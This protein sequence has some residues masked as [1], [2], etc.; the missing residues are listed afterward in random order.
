MTNRREFL[1]TATAILGLH[2]AGLAAAVSKPGGSRRGLQLQ[3]TVRNTGVMELSLVWVDIPQPADD[4]V[5]VRIEGAPINP[6]DLFMLFGPADLSSARVSGTGEKTVMT[7]DIPQQR[8]Q[9]LAN[10]VDKS[11]PAGNEGAGVVVATGASAAAQALLGRTVA[12]RAGA[13]YSQYRCVQARACLVLPQG[14]TPAQGASCFVNP[15]TVLCMVETMRREGYT[16]L[17]HTAAASN[18]GRML[19][20]LCMNEHIGLVNIV[21]R[22]EQV[23]L[24]QGLGAKYVCNSSLPAF[25]EDLTRALR[26]TGATLAFDAVGGGTLA[27]QILTAMENAALQ[28]GA[29]SSPYGSS[30]RKQ[31]YIY[32]GLDRSPTLLSGFYGTAWNVGGWLVMNVLQQIGAEA[33]RT[34]EQKIAAEI[35]TTFASTYAKEVSLA[36]VLQPDAVAAY[37]RNA[38][39]NKYLVNPSKAI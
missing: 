18:L 10:R 3:S 34:M 24:L 21:R 13:M 22:Q 35:T 19:N 17:V 4:E 38:T 25:M 20:R 9:A 15:L 14:T 6:S 31:V 2:A 26:E 32:G 1:Q 7:A 29:S 39:G 8:M 23:D 30:V 37:S 11:M 27:G 36:E 16:A 5:V 33:T 28:S 12:M